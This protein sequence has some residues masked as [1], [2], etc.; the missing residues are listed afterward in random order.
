MLFLVELLS[1]AGRTVRATLV[2]R[3]FLPVAATI[4]A[5]GF[6]I[7][8]EG[9]TV[10]SAV[11]CYGSGWVLS[12]FL[13]VSLARVG[14]PGEIWKARDVSMGRQWLGGALP[15]LLQSF[16]MTQFAGLGIV[17]LE[18]Y[19]PGE[20][21]VGLY[22]AC[23]QVAAFAVL[24]STSTARYYAPLISVCVDER[25][26]QGL[27]RMKHRRHAWTA[28]V[29]VVY[30]GVVF[31]FG[32]KI[33]S[34]FGP[35]FED[36]YVALCI[37]ATGVAAGVLFAMAPYVLQF[38]GKSRLVLATITTATLVNVL[39]LLVL[40]GPFGATGAAVSYSI[41]LGGM[42]LALYLMAVYGAR[43]DVEEMP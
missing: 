31:L 40:A 30:L 38:V 32:R 25:D 34:L 8:G 12:L 5:A 17:V 27:M 42:S 6:H 1:A 21:E 39:L 3:L 23:M 28:P 15:F 7:R 35:G 20:F 41:S 16:M 22:A 2:Y 37:L 36:G 26:W 18:M 24:L 19:R 14:L 11:F 33:L 9:L 43:P 13:L 4:L 10:R 29:V